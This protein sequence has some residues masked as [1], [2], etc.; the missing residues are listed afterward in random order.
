VDVR[1]D[2]VVVRAHGLDAPAARALGGE[3]ARALPDTLAA[4]TYAAPH[5]ISRLDVPALHLNS[6]RSS[7]AEAIAQALA[8]RLDRGE[9]DGA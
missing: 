1:V 8:R 4:A 2:R 7:I 3:I 6:Q 9:G 5:A